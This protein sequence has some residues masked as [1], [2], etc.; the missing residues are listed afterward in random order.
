MGD[1]D[2]QDGAGTA[3]TVPGSPFPGFAEAAEAVLADLQGRLGL[4]LWLVT[5]AVGEH[6][7]VLHAQDAPEGYGIT[8]GTVLSW[9][10]S[11]CTVMAAGD[12][13]HVAPRVADV[14]AYAT[15]PNRAVAPI[16]AYV[17]VPLVQPD[18]ELFG[19]LCA[20]DP[21]PQPG[22]LV[23]AEDLVV[24]QARLLSTVLHLELGTEELHRRAERAETD[25]TTDVLT[26]LGN[27]RGWEQVLAAEETRCSR[28]GHPASVL[29]V[30]LDELKVVNDGSGH[31]AGDELLRRAAEVL[32]GSLRSTDYVA[33]VGGD[34]FAVLAVETGPE[35][36]RV[37]ADRLREALRG[38]GIA[39]A[40]GLGSRAP[41]RSL[42][43]AWRDA[44]AD[45]YRQKPSRRTARQD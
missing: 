21:E 35:G 5:R 33:R 9:S 15:A 36:G 41:D 40:L 22:A 12:G 34:E 44:D 13:P 27:R 10:G 45:M 6:Q 43:D 19:T 23:E 39:A 16:E 3:A 29:V 42:T 4:T 31:A 17:G 38:A 26:G 37:E 11:L 8:A 14:P 2:H 24:L 1:D 28:Y 30:D 7:V 18:G 25:A 32:H 20:F